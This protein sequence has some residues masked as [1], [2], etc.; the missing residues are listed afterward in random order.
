M[1]L[2]DGMKALVRMCVA[3]ANADASV[4][5]VIELCE[6]MMRYGN[7]DMFYIA[8]YAIQVLLLTEVIEV[9]EEGELIVK[10][11]VDETLVGL[12]N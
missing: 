5:D 4:E 11:N 1:I 12:A 2:D 3:D 8:C 10:N 9:N 7:I 6:I